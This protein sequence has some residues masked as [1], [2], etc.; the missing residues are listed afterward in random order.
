MSLCHIMV[1]ADELNQ[2]LDMVGLGPSQKDVFVNIFNYIEDVTGEWFALDT[3]KAQSLHV[4]HDPAL[5]DQDDIYAGWFAFWMCV[6]NNTENGSELETQAL[7]AIRG[8]FFTAAHNRQVTL[9][10]AIETWWQQTNELHFNN[11]LNEVSA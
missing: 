8:L 10:S 5:I 1:M 2:T 6:F 9:P 4:A 7:G 11:S 3:A